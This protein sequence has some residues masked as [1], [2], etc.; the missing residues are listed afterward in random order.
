MLIWGLIGL[1]VLVNAYI[2]YTSYIQIH[3][4]LRDAGNGK[5]IAGY[6]S[7]LKN[8]TKACNDIASELRSHRSRIT[9]LD[10]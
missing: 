5:F 4:P 6:Q 3:Y 7:E 2:I 1:G 9:S 10:L 8:P